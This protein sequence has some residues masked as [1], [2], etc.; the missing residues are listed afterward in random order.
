MKKIMRRVGKLPVPRLT[1]WTS[2]AALI[3]SVLLFT[4]G[5]TLPAQAAIVASNGKLLLPG[6]AAVRFSPPTLVD[7]DGDGLQDILVGTEDGKVY[8]LKYSSSSPNLA[9]MWS[10]DTSIDLGCPTAIRGAISAADLDGDGVVEV[11]IAVGQALAAKCGGL[12]VLN[13]QTGAAKWSFHTH[14]LM[15]NATDNP[16]PEGLSDP[17]IGAP[18][19]GDLDNDG[20]LEIV[21]GSIGQHV[22][23][24]HA[25]GTPVDGWPRFIRD[26][27]WSSPALADLDND[28]LLEVIIGS[29]THAEPP[30]IN[31]QSGG[32]MWVF[33]ADGTL[34]PGWPQFI[35]QN[36][37]SSPAVGDL[38]NDGNLEVIAGTG[39]YYNPLGGNP[40]GNHVYVWNKSGTLLWTGNTGGYVMSSPALGMLDGSGK[41][42]VVAGANDGK[43]YAWNHDGTLF[44]STTPQSFTSYTQTLITSPILADYNG[45]GVADVFVNMY[46]NATVLNGTNGFQLTANYIPDDPDP[47]YVSDCTVS[48]NAPALGDIDGDGKLELVLASGD[49]V[50]PNCGTAQVD[51]WR[52]NVNVPADPANPTSAPWMMFGQDARHTHLYPKRLSWDSEV[53]SHTI[54]SMMAPGQ[55]RQVS[56]TLKN[57][58]TISWQASDS[59]R[60]H[61]IGNSDPFTTT[62]DF[63]LNPGEAVATGETRTFNMLLTAPATS[64]L[65]T[66]DWRL[67]SNSVSQDFGRTVKVNIKVGSQPAAH[68]LTTLNPTMYAVG[69]A[70]SAFQQPAN[71]LFP[72]KVKFWKL[73]LDK[74]G[75]HMLDSEGGYWF[76]GDVVPLAPLG[77]AAGLSHPPDLR[78][79][80]LGPDGF[81]YYTLLGN[82]RIIPCDNMQCDPWYRVFTPTIPISIEARALALTSDGKGAYVMTGHG[83]LYRGGTAPALTLPAGFP[84]ASDLVRRIRLTPNGTGYYAMDM[85][86]RIWNGGSA[87]PMTLGYTPHIGTDWAR[88]FELTPDG[89]GFYLLSENDVIYSGGT[90]EPLVINLPPQS[91]NSGQDLEMMDGRNLPRLRSSAQA[92][93][94]THSVGSNAIAQATITISNAG[95][96]QINWNANAA[97]SSLEFLPTNGILVFGAPSQVQIRVNNP[98]AYSLGTFHFTV[99]ISGSAT[100]P[101]ESSPQMVAVT[102]VVA[103]RIYLPLLRR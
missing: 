21:F 52:M 73:T 67:V 40:A 39:D 83:Q 85:Y 70:T 76:G 75:Y 68:D 90:A 77:T 92:V 72:D 78:D 5:R 57:T 14:D 99:S 41:L 101:V 54:P 96:S 89:T 33:R 93:T 37:Y 49:N 98:A 3:G 59:L 22:Y 15:E 30:P 17:V 44:W 4:V 8:A 100:S 71:L 58:G 19:L 13:G 65:Y 47:A 56:I 84:L 48:D 97:P 2:L 81:S 34:L 42:K 62:T 80:A 7:L 103:N 28:G 12:E 61:A 66:T 31:T 50:G 43:M 55:S 23:A 16:H 9:V 95:P 64:G 82:G 11:V 26:A 38:D 51:F 79:M 27:I 94:I 87:P 29:D 25:D 86:G 91:A 102:L 18:A 6:A 46:W 32:R 24:L 10:H 69:S 35:A 63:N 1:L 20:K 74:R 45:D 88:D 36:F 60:L 53:V